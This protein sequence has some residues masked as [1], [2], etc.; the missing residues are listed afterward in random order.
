[1]QWLFP[2]VTLGLSSR[3]ITI[4][5]TT[6]GTERL[7]AREAEALLVHYAQLLTLTAPEMM[8]LVGGPRVLGANFGKSTHGVFIKRPGTPTNDF[9]INLLDLNT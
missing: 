3:V 6:T 7:R 4:I 5:L 1:L 2:V 9:F 8:V